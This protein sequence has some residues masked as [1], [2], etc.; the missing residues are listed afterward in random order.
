MI[1]LLLHS[2]NFFVAHRIDHSLSL[3]TFFTIWKF[4]SPAFPSCVLFNLTGLFS[5]P[6]PSKIL[7]YMHS[8][9]HT[10]PF[11]FFP[12]SA[13]QSPDHTASPAGSP[14]FSTALNFYSSFATLLTVTIILY[15]LN[16]P[17]DLAFFEDRA[18]FHVPSYPQ[19]QE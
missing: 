10:F 11:A 7:H 5:V 14:P 8:F 6:G 3:A 17:L 9:S 19:C 4:T 16:L 15:K 18:V 13:L 2:K 1:T 12:A